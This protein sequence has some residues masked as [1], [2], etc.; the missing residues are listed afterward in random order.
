MDDKTIESLL[1]REPENEITSAIRAFL[2]RLDIEFKV[3]L[4]AN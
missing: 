1:A 4:S 3:H 2:K